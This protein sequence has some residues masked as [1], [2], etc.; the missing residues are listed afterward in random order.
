[1]KSGSTLVFFLDKILKDLPEFF[2][3]AP[4]FS[5]EE[6]FVPDKVKEESY[7]RKKLITEEEDVDA[8]GFGNKGGY[9]P[10]SKFA[11]VILSKSVDKTPEEILQALNIPMSLF[12]VLII[13]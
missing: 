9:Y 1:M 7:F 13:S 11:A 10:D 6:L 12:D 4:F 5:V 8:Q 2:K 3:G